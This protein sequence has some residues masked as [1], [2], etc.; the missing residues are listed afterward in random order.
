[1]Q[2]PISRKVIGIPQEACSSLD[3]GL[4][5]AEAKLVDVD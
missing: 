4:G 5:L 3:D 1:M 2:I